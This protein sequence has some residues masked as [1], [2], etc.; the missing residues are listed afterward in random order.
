MKLVREIRDRLGGLVFRRWELLRLPWFSVFLHG[1][2][3]RRGDRDAHCH[4]HPWSFWNL[5][6]WGGYD[7][8][9]HDTRRHWFRRRG[10]L[11]LGRMPASGRFHRILRLR[12]DRS[13]SLVVA[14]RST[15]LWGYWTQDG[16]VDNV[17]YRLRKNAGTLAD[18]GHALKVYG[19]TG[20]IAT[21]KSGVAEVFMDK[22]IPVVDADV[23]ARIVVWP[24]KPAYE[25]IV[26]EFGPQIL[27]ATHD[28]GN[29]HIDRRKLGAIVFADPAKRKR[30]EEI[31]HPHIRDALA[32][33][34]R[35]QRAAGH[36]VVVYDAALLV[37]TGG[38]R[39]M[40]GL[41][42]TACPR[43]EQLRRLMGRDKLTRQQAEAR[44]AAQISPER[45][46]F[47]ADWVVDTGGTRERTRAQVEKIAEEMLS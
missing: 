38:Y 14:G 43:E 20:G 10:L 23:L 45:R 34:L 18:H 21:G 24:G 19:L 5:V 44:L 12:G 32:R 33:E 25:E 41:V 1:M 27:R 6:L 28:H 42:V 4:D 9:V 13:Y 15:R 16:W 46:E 35:H 11:T 36:R 37:E 8:V 22:G 2:Y 26:R 7:E 17:T 29:R 39:A 40:E 47:L 30:L 31:T 3:D